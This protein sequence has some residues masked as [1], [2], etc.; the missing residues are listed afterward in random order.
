MTVRE[1]LTETLNYWHFTWTCT[2]DEKRQ[3]GKRTLAFFFL[4]GPSQHRFCLSA[5]LLLSRTMKFAYLS[6]SLSDALN[7]EICSSVFWEAE[8][9]QRTR[10]LIQGHRFFIAGTLWASCSRFLW[11]KYQT[12]CV[13]S[14]S[15]GLRTPKTTD[16]QS[17]PQGH[18][19]Y[20]LG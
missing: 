3:G 14:Y 15:P 4:P 13:F 16:T 8:R 17:T 1:V 9:L 11:F 10:Y 5:A 20:R 12:G 19:P 6:T 18:M 2:K 7:L